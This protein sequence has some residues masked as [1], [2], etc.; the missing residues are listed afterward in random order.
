VF[1]WAGASKHPLSSSQKNSA[2]TQ[3]PKVIDD[4]TITCELPTEAA[5]GSTINI[6][7]FTQTITLC[8][9][10]STIFKTLSAIKTLSRTPEEV[11]RVLSNLHWQ[12]LQWRDSQPPSLRPDGPINPSQIP[13]G[14]H[15]YHLLFL[16]YSYYGSLMAIHSIY[17][18][19][20]NSSLIGSSSLSSVRE[21]INTSSTIV[22]EASRNIIL[23][24]KYI[25]INASL[26]GWYANIQLFNTGS[27]KG[28]TQVSFRLLIYYPLVGFLNAFIHVVKNPTLPSTEMDLALMDMI[29]GHFGHLGFLSDSNMAFA[30]PRQIAMLTSTVVMNAR[31]QDEIRS[32]LSIEENEFESNLFPDVSLSGLPPPT[33]TPLSSLIDK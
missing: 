15:L 10:S 8:R 27:R 4:D 5:E 18:Y 23:A 2:D 12:I 24:T 22:I 1:V 3:S 33:Y 28:L 6:E 17:A 19:P 7:I 25:D 20:W 26:P 21:Q 14:Y 30:F 11:I 29:V 32:S 31:K 9:I 13:P 16:H